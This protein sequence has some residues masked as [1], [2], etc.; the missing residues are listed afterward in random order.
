MQ[1][2]HYT[3]DAVIVVVLEIRRAEEIC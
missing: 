2:Y 3:L 1:G